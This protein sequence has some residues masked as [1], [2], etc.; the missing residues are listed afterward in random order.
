[1]MATLDQYRGCLL[2]LS[3]GDAMGAPFEGGVIERL[4]WWFIGKTRCGEIRWTDDTVMSIDIVESFLANGSID[5]DDLAVR[6][7]RS[8][9]FSRGYGPGTAR[10]LKRI[11]KGGNWREVNRSIYPSGSFG[12]GAA[13]RAPIIGLIFADRIAEL[14]SVIRQSAIVT[15]AH[16]LGIEGAVLLGF[17]TARVS[18]GLKSSEILS[19]LTARCTQEPFLSR[20][21]IAG[22]W[23]KSAGDIH[24][25]EVRRHLGNGVAA[26]TSCVTA[27]YLA[28]RFRCRSFTE[29]QEFVI[30]VG[31]DVDTIGAMA[32]AVWGVANGSALLPLETLRKLEQRERLEQLAADLHRYVESSQ[33]S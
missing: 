20:L 16:E 13:M 15:H 9:R 25:R 24:S 17:A 22:D 26:Q 1:M 10:L 5:P 2:G 33:E 21:C 18:R 14:P 19:E 3:L 7:A 29:L 23:L 31:G 6:F 4:L 12:N 32:G 8:Y 27:L 11:A 30:Q 28:L